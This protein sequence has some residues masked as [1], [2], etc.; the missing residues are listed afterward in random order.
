MNESLTLNSIC[1]GAELN[2]HCSYDDS[3]FLLRRGME[4]IFRI[5]GVLSWSVY[6]SYI[7]L[8]C[9]L[10]GELLISA[11][12]LLSIEIIPITNQRALK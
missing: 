12:L 4:K 10:L 11:L 7:V 2:L 6:T 5:W 9:H 1:L 8:I 3:N